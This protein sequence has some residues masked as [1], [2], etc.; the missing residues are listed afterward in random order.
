M[1]RTPAEL[2]AKAREQVRICSCAEA[3][4]WIEHNPHGRVVDVREPAEHAAGPIGGSVNIPRGLIEF[5]IEAACQGPGTP[6]LLFC[7]SGGRAALAAMALEEL[8]YSAVTAVIGSFG[9][10]SKLLAEAD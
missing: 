8:G 7:A 3:V 9:D 5:Q 6:I 10:L 2:V 4:V 1:P